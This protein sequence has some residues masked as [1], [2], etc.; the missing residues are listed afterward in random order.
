MS[1][2]V[3]TRW[4]LRRFFAS[5]RR[6]LGLHQHLLACNV[7]VDIVT[8]SWAAWTVNASGYERILIGYRNSRAISYVKRAMNWKKFETMNEL[9]TQVGHMV[10]FENNRQKNSKCESC[11]AN[12]L[13]DIIII[14]FSKPVSDLSIWIFYGDRKKTSQAFW[15]TWWQLALQ[16]VH[17]HDV[18][19]EHPNRAVN[20]VV[21][22]FDEC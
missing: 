12:E 16:H 4:Q 11:C 7:T 21:F 14:E 6:I 2:Q 5:H 19:D 20:N 15:L 17:G 10:K 18:Y 9:T 22:R 1:I 8:K 3:V 13:L